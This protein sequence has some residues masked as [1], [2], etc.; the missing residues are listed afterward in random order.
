MLAGRFFDVARRRINTLEPRFPG[1]RSSHYRLLALIPD[2]GSRITDLV[3]EASM[4]KQALGQF[5]RYLQGMGYVEIV[6]DP[7]DRRAKIVR[8]SDRGREAEQAGMRVLA[9]LEEE[10]REQV[11]DRRYSALRKT[12]VDLGRSPVE[13]TASGS[14][15]AGTLPR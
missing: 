3:D 10:W 2:D 4:T 7:T 14:M 15:R 9:D 6:V 12:L 11:G 1:L 5:A 13:T 8:K